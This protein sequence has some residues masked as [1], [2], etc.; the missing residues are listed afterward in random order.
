V[1]RLKVGIL[2]GG[3]SGEHEISL[4]S[5]RSVIQALDKDRYD[6]VPIG[7][8]K[9]GE[10]LTQGDPMSALEGRAGEDRRDV[11][12]RVARALTKASTLPNPF[13]QVNVVLPLLHGPFG[14][15]GT[16]QGL[17]EMANIPYAG[18]GVLAS[19]LGMDKAFMKRVFQ[20]QGLA[21][22]RF[23]VVHQTEWARDSE[24]V[25]TSAGGLGYPLFV[26]PVNGGSSVGISKVPNPQTLPGALGLAFRYS[27]KVVLEE[28]IEARE[29]ECSVL[30]ND[31]PR[32]SIPGEVVCASDFYDY[33][34]KYADSG[35]RLV[36][37][38]VLEP[39]LVPRFQELALAAFR[40]IDCRGMARVDF[41]LRRD[42]GAILVNE[43]NTIPGFTPM[44]MFPRLWE[45]SGV[46]F[47]ELVDT[48]IQLALEEH[49]DKTGR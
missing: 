48:L 22:P 25:L 4:L 12:D 1:S 43:I 42:D 40:A 15:D 2:F 10:W 5:A 49:A 32:V 38:A 17:L 18:A 20:Q 16:V 27:R 23:E 30:G 21:V 33:D 14:E 6:I 35:T 3:V 24:S 28:T 9:E 11:V 13:P 41:F 26:K 29:I 7:I 47:T 34:A 31:D 46:S 19:A 45:A 36:I 44:S 39:G 8:T 37:P